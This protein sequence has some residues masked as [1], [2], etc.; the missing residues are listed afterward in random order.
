VPCDAPDGRPRAP[1]DR[2][3][4]PRQTLGRRGE[5]LAAEHLRRLGFGLLARNHRT[6]HGEIDL[7][8]FDGRTLVFVEV[9]AV[10]ATACRRARVGGVEPLARLRARQR[11]R[12]RRLASAWL[13]DDRCTRPTA[14][15]I[16]FDAIGVAVDAGGAAARIDHVQGA[17]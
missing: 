7:I 4:D 17:W 14:A 5:L 3:R 16:R 9:K 6:R 1:A 10:R 15:T 12:L 2:R 11:L 13:A 8:A